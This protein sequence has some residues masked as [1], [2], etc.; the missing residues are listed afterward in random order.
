M[1]KKE[2]E[3]KV[4]LE[5]EY[6]VPLRSKW[7]K[8]PEYKRANKAIRSLK[9][10]L[11]KHMKDYD[12]D[13]RN[14]KID[15]YLNE[16]IRFRGMRKPASKIKVKVKKYDNGKIVAELGEIP[17]ALKFKML[18][19]KKIKAEE[20]KKAEEVKKTEPVEEKK[21]EKTEEEK[22]ETKEKESSTVDAGLKAQDAQAKQSKHVSGTKQKQPKIHRMSLKK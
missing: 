19:E 2:Q 11:A 4:I 7:L 18:K 16:E 9:E 14:V 5:R 12:R 17:A 10:F 1:A 8:A 3:P 21:E 22:K 6:T 15:H 20:E 13:L